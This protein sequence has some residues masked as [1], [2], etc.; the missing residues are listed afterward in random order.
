MIKTLKYIFIVYSVFWLNNILYSQNLIGANTDSSKAELPQSLTVTD[1][2]QT[3]SAAADTAV[4]SSSRSTNSIEFPVEYEAE[5]IENSIDR[6]K[7]VLK[8]K[9]KVT[10]QNIYLKAAE[11]VV[12]WE[13]NSMTAQG[14]VDSV[15][16]KDKE[17]GD[18]TKTERWTGLPEFSESGDIMNGE[19][20]IFNLKTKKGRVLRGRT[21]FE[22]GYYKGRV[23]KMVKPKVMYVSN[24]IFTTCDREKD[25]H[26]HFWSSKMRIDVGKKI[27]AKPIVM[28]IG[29]IPVAILPFIYF[30]MSRKRRSSGIIIPRYGES[31]SQGRYL[32]GLGY[33]FTPSDYWDI[34]A[35]VDYF[36][37]SGFLFQSRLNYNLRYRMSGSISGSWTKNDFDI[38]GTKERRWSL[39]I[40]HSQTI[41]PTMSLN[42]NGSF[43]SSG[44]LYKEISS[45]RQMRLRQS[46]R[47]NATFRKTFKGSKSLTI[48]LNQTRNLKTDEISETL[49]KISFRAGRMPIFTKP[50]NS[51]EM[52][53][54]HNI[55]FSYSSAA[56]IEREKRAMTDSTFTENRDMAVDHKISLSAPL[57]FLKYLSWNPN[58]NYDEKWYSK[59]RDYYLDPETREIE[60]REKK[61]FFALRTFRFSSSF[62]TKL[63][64]IFRPWFLKNTSFRHVL[65]PNVSFNY[66]PNFTD[67]LWGYYQAVE[68]SSGEEQQ[69]DRYTGSIY[70][71][72]PSGEIMS[73]SFSVRNLFQMKTG[74]EKDEK[75]FNLL[76]WNISSGY[77]WKAEKYKLSDFRSSINA[78][79]TS[80]LRINIGITHSPYKVDQN[81][82]K[83]DQMYMSDI[84]WDDFGSIF[85]SRLFRLTRFSTSLNFKLKGS[86]GTDKKEKKKEEESDDNGFNQQ[87]IGM[88]LDGIGLSDMNGGSPDFAIPWDLDLSFRY[89]D[90]R[91]NPLD[92]KKTFYMNANLNFNL[93]R[94]WKITCRTR[95][96]F[97]EGKLISE[98]LEFYRDL[99]CWEARFVWSPIGIYK[100]FYFKINIKASMLRDIKYE[101][102]TG[103][104]GFSPSSLS[105]F[106]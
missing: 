27:I 35:T 5:L 87:D 19:K 64:G 4:I 95:Y 85:S 20:M 46:I 12:D 94:H 66:Q 62:G 60:Y 42:I 18:S 97:V 47:S 34:K 40:N 80:N 55:S 16:I 98:D 72:T 86:I 81:G 73:V 106:Y 83:I 63:Y 9:A 84:N 54:Y 3:D 15:W 38:S 70:G 65:T 28:H 69:Y 105:Q 93:T 17:T 67:R 36:E 22:R 82:N 30:P 23:M 39:A 7:T 50:E 52:R 49:P 104:R 57:K 10:Y 51:N 79:P 14:V 61:G 25:P 59:R 92:P 1:T 91:S 100:H 24:A 74:K 53:W 26:F 37:K 43:V 21:Q 6:K 77:N 11:I 2:V 29:N 48:N 75:K 88:G 44:A 103:T 96:D 99:H 56:V 89:N 68:D 90:Y 101:K 102:G 45:S 76:T 13:N 58:I 32:R 78:N 33:Y 41:S 31:S 71:S 8:G